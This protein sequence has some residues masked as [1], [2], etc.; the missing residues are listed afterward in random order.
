MVTGVILAGGENK[1]MGGKIKALLMFAGK[2]IVER[3]IREMKQICDDIIVVTNT[4]EPFLPI[5]DKSVRVITD[6]IPGKGPMSGMLAAFSAAGTP[7]V[8]VVG[9][10]MPHISA[11]AAQ[12]M[13]NKRRKECCDAVIPVLEGKMHPLHGIYHRNCADVVSEHLSSGQHRLMGMIDRLN[14][15]E[16][17]ADFFLEAGIDLRFVSNL[18]TPEEYARALEDTGD[19]FDK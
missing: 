15:A 17:D 6:Q 16:T 11:R 12:L 7:E 19:G 14:W 9:S 4:P 5:L 18:N 3:Q 2:R 13:L 8:W 1:R 10:D